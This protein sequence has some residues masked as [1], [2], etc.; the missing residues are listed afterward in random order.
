MALKSLYLIRHGHTEWHATGGVAGSSDIA[1]AE[2]GRDAIR[3]LAAS[4]QQMMVTPQAWYCS[5]M[6]RTRQSSD[7]LREH[8]WSDETGSTAAADRILP[9]TLLDARL[10]ELDFGDWEGMTWAD[11]HEQHADVMQAW[12]EDWVNRAPPGGERFASQAARCQAWLEEARKAL[13][14][15]ES[16][17]AVV[18]SH[19]GSIRALL[20]LCL[21]WSL[22][23]AMSFRVDPASLTH[24]Q[25]D[26]SEARWLTRGI[27][28][29]RAP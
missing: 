17:S 7:L 3:Q 21:G 20:C 19:G 16:A 18:V 11:V 13:A 25:F 2:Q 6:L 8:W 1:L 26:A 15:V 28:V 29:R 10:V 23:R 9:D 5:P 27:N 22:Q 12:A 4:L 24:L 14:D